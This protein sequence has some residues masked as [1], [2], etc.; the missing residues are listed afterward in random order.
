MKITID[1][2]QD[3]AIRAEVRKIAEGQIRGIIREELRQLVIDEVKQKVEAFD[4]RQIFHL[5]QS[6]TEKAM[7][8]VLHE[9]HNI[10]EWTRDGI[11]E[12]INVRVDRFLTDMVIIDGIE[13]GVQLKL[14]KLVG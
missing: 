2:E 6:S 7:L 9:E 4:T 13:K 10:S 12:F 14:K 5:V 1:L 8:K 3:G 11:Q